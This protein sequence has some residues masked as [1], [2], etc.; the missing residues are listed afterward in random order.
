VP[1]AKCPMARAPSGA[2]NKAGPGAQRPVPICRADVVRVCAAQAAMQAVMARARAPAHDQ[3]LARANK[4]LRP[5]THGNG[6]MNN[7]LR[8]R[9]SAT[10]LMAPHS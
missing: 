1:W 9:T 2:A 10:C 8:S 3:V 7:Y 5:G 4:P 6:W